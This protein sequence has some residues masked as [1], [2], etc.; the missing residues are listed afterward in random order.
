[1]RG[2]SKSGVAP[3]FSSGRFAG[4]EDD[5]SPAKTSSAFW[6]E[7][8]VPKK[9]LKSGVS[10]MRRPRNTRNPRKGTRNFSTPHY[11]SRHLVNF[12]QGEAAGVV[13]AAD[14]RRVTA[15]GERD[16]QHGVLGRSRAKLE[17]P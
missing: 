1:M 7:G 14:H 5:H 13:H 3:A 2:S 6:A 11:T 8:A 9:F 15:G 16:E 4:G 12:H 17:G 10:D